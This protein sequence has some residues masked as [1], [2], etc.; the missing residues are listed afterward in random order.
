MRDLT[1]EEFIKRVKAFFKK[2]ENQRY[3]YLSL[4]LL[5]FSFFLG[6]VVRPTVKSAFEARI[7]KGELLR[8]TTQLEEYINKAVYL[9]S[10]LEKYREDMALIYQA[11]PEEARISSVMRDIATMLENNRLVVLDASISEIHL[12]GE[13]KKDLKTI[14]LEYLLSGS[15]PN[16]LRFLRDLENQRRLKVVKSVSVIREK[17]GDIVVSTNE[18]NLASPESNLN[19]KLKI[20][21]YFL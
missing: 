6:F 11:L 7:K 9:Q 14:G 4:F 15:F 16:F 19:I 21:V 18:S 12:V 1:L 20:E 3:L 2:E 13:E 10:E 8:T 17:Q 5:A